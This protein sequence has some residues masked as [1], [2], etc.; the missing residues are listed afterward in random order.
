MSTYIYFAVCAIK[1]AM[2]GGETVAVAPMRFAGNPVRRGWDSDQLVDAQVS[3]QN[4]VKAEWLNVPR[5]AYLVHEK[6]DGSFLSGTPVYAWE[7]NSTFFSDGSG[8]LDCGTQV[9][10]LVVNE[11]DSLTIESM[12]D[13][14]VWLSSGPQWHHEYFERFGEWYKGAAH[15]SKWLAA[16]TD[17]ETAE[18]EAASIRAELD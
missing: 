1:T 14:R 16:V 7:K 8:E 15:F 12:D 11:D 17:Q 10:V 9:G 4:R 13:A 3:A 5:P 2:F 6:N 18:Y